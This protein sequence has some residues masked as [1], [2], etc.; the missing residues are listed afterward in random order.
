MVNVNKLSTEMQKELA[1]TKEEL[2]ELNVPITF[3]D[4][5]KRHGGGNAH[6]ASPAAKRAMARQQRGYCFFWGLR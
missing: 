3:D 2:A 4:C 1:F 5:P 6:G